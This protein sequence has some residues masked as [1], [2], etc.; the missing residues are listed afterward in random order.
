MERKIK[1]PGMIIK[2]LSSVVT[3]LHWAFSINMRTEKAKGEKE[4]IIDYRRHQN[5]IHRFIHI[6]YI[7]CVLGSRDNIL[8]FIF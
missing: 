5:W 1:E 3:G 8:K 7:C 2:C 6:I 4:Q